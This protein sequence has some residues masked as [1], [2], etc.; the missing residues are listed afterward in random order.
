MQAADPQIPSQLDALLDF[1]AE[2]AV[3]GEGL[4][5]QGAKGESFK[6][7]SMF[8]KDLSIGWV[9]FE[10]KR[11]WAHRGILGVKWTRPNLPSKRAQAR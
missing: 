5:A 7:Q 8:E 10:A 11:V 3:N 9:H 4:D 2:N 6:K 1:L